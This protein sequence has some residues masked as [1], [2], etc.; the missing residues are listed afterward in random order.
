MRYTNIANKSEFT[1]HID[2]LHVRIV[3][4]VGVVGLVM[5]VTLVLTVPLALALTAAVTEVLRWVFS[6]HLVIGFR[7]IDRR[8]LVLVL[9]VSLRDYSPSRWFA[10]LVRFLFAGCC[11]GRAFA[12]G[13]FWRVMT[14]RNWSLSLSS[15]LNTVCCGCFLVR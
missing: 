1:R 13:V 7:F 4:D 2:D 8:V 14:V 12:G 10:R 15:V 11:L 9:V 6:L 5:A 3:D